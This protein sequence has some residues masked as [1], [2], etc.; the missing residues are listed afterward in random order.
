VLR[1]RDGRA[2]DRKEHVITS[3]Q[4]GHVG[5]RNGQTVLNLCGKS[6]LQT[7]PDGLR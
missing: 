1:R 5:V 2:L 4:G 3:P 6:L 7:V